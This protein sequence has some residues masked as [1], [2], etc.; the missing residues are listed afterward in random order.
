MFE[1]RGLGLRDRVTTEVRIRNL[2]NSQWAAEPGPP[3]CRRI[4]G[5]LAGIEDGRGCPNDAR[6]I[7]AVEAESFDANIGPDD[8]GRQRQAEGPTHAANKAPQ[9]PP[10]KHTEEQPEGPVRQTR[11]R[12]V[13][14]D[15]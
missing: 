9:A 13:V 1:D 11:P 15:V 4:G 12:G 7:V 10:W 6:S 3:R 8:A 14:A 2:M 5:R